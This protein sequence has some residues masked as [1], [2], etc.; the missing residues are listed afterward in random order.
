MR[1][2]KNTSV[3]MT[4]DLRRIICK[5]HAHMKR[6]ERKPAPNWKN[7]N[8]KISGR[9]TGG[10]RGYAY[11]GGHGY[12]WDVRFTLG[13]N[14]TEVGFAIAVYHELMHTYGYRHPQ[15]NDLPFAEALLLFPDNVDIPRKVK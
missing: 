6:L 9:P 12:E 2:F 3:Y 4:K 11:Y 8:V 15:Y 10:W 14:M 5:V 13:C 7:L 1:I